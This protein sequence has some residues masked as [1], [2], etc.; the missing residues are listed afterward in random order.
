M[1]ETWPRTAE[2][3]K[4]NKKRLENRE[5]GKFRG[6][7]WHRFGR[8][9]NLG[10]QERAKVCVPRLVEYL[11]AAADLD[12][13]HFL[14]NVDVG[15]VTFK[16]SAADHSLAYLLALLN[17]RVLRWYFPQISAPFQGGFRS[18]NKQFLSLVPFCP[19]DLTQPAGQSRHGA[20]VR[21]VEWLLWLHRQP[22]V[23]ESSSAH[24]RDPLIAAYFEQWVNALVYELYFPEELHAATLHF[25]DLSATHALSPPPKEASPAV[26]AG[27]REHFEQLY[28]TDHPLRAALFGLGSLEFVRII[29]GK[30]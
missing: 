6:N 29:E 8:S 24:P 25:F 28:A 13:A 1:S 15:G 27:L 20:V 9:Q 10:I 23:R 5:S 21:L 26:L 3:L 11:H 4:E 2:Y 16:D 30:A 12:G 14:D 19:L 17:S 7:G 18:A 22:S